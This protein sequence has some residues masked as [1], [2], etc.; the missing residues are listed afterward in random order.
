MVGAVSSRALELSVGQGVPAFKPGAQDMYVMGGGETIQLCELNVVF[1]EETNTGAFLKIP[2]KTVKANNHG[3][4]T[5]I[6][7]TSSVFFTF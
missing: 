5:A 1:D 7:I 6:S 2:V 4:T 3:D